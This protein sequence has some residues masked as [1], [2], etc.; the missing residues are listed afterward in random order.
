MPT[1]RILKCL[2][3]TADPRLSRYLICASLP[4][5]QLELIGSPLT[6][7]RFLRRP[8]GTYGATF[9]SALPNSATPIRN[10]VVCGDSIFPGT[11]PCCSNKSHGCAHTECV[12]WT[13]ISRLCAHVRNPK[14]FRVMD[15]RYGKSSAT[16]HL[17]ISKSHVHTCH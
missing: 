15:T 8:R 16:Y 10:L 11:T 1:Q 7:E 12:Q 4:I 3:E 13:K 2:S 6:H 9:S 17:A 14:Y 5:R